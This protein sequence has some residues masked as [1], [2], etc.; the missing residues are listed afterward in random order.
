MGTEDKNNDV[1][2]KR[3]FNEDAIEKYPDI[4]GR[5]CKWGK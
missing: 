5:L 2:F 1:F 4:P 3:L